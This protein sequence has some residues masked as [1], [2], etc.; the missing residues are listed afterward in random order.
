MEIILFLELILLI[1][2]F[3]GVFAVVIFFI[4]KNDKGPDIDSLIQQYE[5]QMK[6]DIEIL[7]LGNKEIDK[8]EEKI[9]ICK[10]KLNMKLFNK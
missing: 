8:L 1:L 9:L 10:K 4:R 3:F 7:E 2:C 5:N 6:N